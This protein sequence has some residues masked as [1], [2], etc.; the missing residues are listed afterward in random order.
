MGWVSTKQPIYS[1]SCRLVQ[2]FL[3][4]TNWYI[5]RKGPSCEARFV[6]DLGV[7][8]TDGPSASMNAPPTRSPSAG[9]FRL[10]LLPPANPQFNIQNSYQA[11]A[12]ADI[13]S[14]EQERH[15][16]L[17]LLCVCTE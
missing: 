15:D 11:L 10:G 12:G 3:R 17:S 5:S 7:E 2:R 4:Y 14:L 16:H 9:G 13:S 6:R 8:R 1:G